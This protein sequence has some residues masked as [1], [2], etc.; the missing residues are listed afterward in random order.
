MSDP[1]SRNCPLCGGSAVFN[2]VELGKYKHFVC[3]NCVE[4]LISN[5][6]EERVSGA[7]QDWR[8]QHSISAR[9]SNEEK[10]WVIHLGPAGRPQ[11]GSATLALE[12]ELFSRSKVRL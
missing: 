11:A 4:F 7:I 1:Q 5:A 2:F 10:I 8:D 6:A 9:Q 3:K 12:G